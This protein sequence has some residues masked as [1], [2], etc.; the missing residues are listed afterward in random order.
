M[1][2]CG[3][4]SRLDPLVKTGVICA[5]FP[6]ESDLTVLRAKHKH[7]SPKGEG[8]NHARQANP[9]QWPAL[10]T[11]LRTPTAASVGSLHISVRPLSLNMQRHC[12]KKKSQTAA[13]TYSLTPDVRNSRTPGV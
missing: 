4:V 8:S 3:R 11:A 6:K 10:N 9:E 13:E 2:P 7:T 1:D 5:P 12:K